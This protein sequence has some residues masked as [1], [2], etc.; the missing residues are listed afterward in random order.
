MRT[1]KLVFAVT[2]SVLMFTFMCVPAL[3]ETAESHDH[4][5]CVECESGETAEN[6][7][8]GKSQPCPCGGVYSLESRT[9]LGISNKVE[10]KC[11]HKTYGTDLTYKKSYN[12]IYRCNLCREAYSITEYENITEC[13]GYY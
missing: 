2:L 8:R 12:A 6:I 9:Y 4:S 13:H 1:I 5:L 10:V 7:A 11:T 3:A